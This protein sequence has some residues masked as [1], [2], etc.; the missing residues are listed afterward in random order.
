MAV[1]IALLGFGTVATG[2]PFLLEE[3]RVKLQAL[4]GD[5][6]VIEKVLVRDEATTKRLRQQGYSYNFVSSFEDIMT[7]D[8]IAIVVELMGRVEP[9]KTYI[10]RA[11][12][13]GKHVVTAN[14][15]LLALHGT[16]LATLAKQQGLGFYYEA[17]VAGGI[18]ILRTLANAFAADKITALYGILN[19]TTNFMLTKMVTEGWTYEAALAEAQTLGYAES[20]PTNDVEGI[21]AAYKLAI[22][23]QFA[24][25]MSVPFEN[26]EH[27]GI[28]HITPEDVIAA[29]QLGYVIKLIGSIRDCSEGL[30]AQVAPTLVPKS[31]QLAGII[32]AMNAVYVE[33]VGIGQSLFYGPGAGQK[34]TA[35]SVLADLVEI[36]RCLTHQLSITPFNR[37]ERV[38]QLATAEDCLG[39]Y[40]LSV[41]CPKE[42]SLMEEEQTRDEKMPLIQKMLDVPIN[43]QQKRLVI[44]TNNISQ[45]T[46]EAFKH[47]LATKPGVTILNSF[48]VLGED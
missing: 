19:G 1:R 6:F 46:F 33:S 40:C 39:Y 4:V 22:L 24:F 9:A 31:H 15:D 41:A 29:D 35:T 3:N 27:Q 5:E 23:C 13:A 17:A 8:A 10:T 48:N 12:L 28:T 32:N 30:Q 34:P 2:L 7:D 44:V 11:L 25:G 36:G 20:D 38:G 16:E 21:D 45:A 26:I 37:F 47:R 14:K 18:P 42:M 43:D